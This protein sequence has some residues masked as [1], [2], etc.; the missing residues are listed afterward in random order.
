MSNE[1][2]QYNTLPKYSEGPKSHLTENV[3][4]PLEAA[5]RSSRNARA[6][7]MLE[8]KNTEIQTINE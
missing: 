8:G 1:S 3:Y 4:Y 5:G 2:N 7:A 6:Q